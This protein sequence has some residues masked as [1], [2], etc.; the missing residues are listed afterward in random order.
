MAAT[1]RPDRPISEAVSEDMNARSFTTTGGKV[2]TA[3]NTTVVISFRLPES[4]RSRIKRVL[5]ENGFTLA[6]GAKTALYQFIKGLE[7][8]GRL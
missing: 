2:G 6:Q 1:K 3:H 4:E 7:K 8:G 5:A